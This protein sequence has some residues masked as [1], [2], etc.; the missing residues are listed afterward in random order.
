MENGVVDLQFSEMIVNAVNLRFMNSKTGET[1][2]EGATRPEV[3]LRQ[4]TTRP[5]QVRAAPGLSFRVWL[6]V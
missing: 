6:R 3:I 1:K 2:E 4:L 5:G